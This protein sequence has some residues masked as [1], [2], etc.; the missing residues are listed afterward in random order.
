ML[1]ALLR[2][3]GIVDIESVSEPLHHRFGLIAA[4]NEKALRAAYEK[5]EK[6]EIRP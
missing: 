6:D 5:V 1:G 2:A 4:K 3:T